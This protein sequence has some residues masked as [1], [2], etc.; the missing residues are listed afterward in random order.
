MSSQANV[1]PRRKTGRPRAEVQLRLLASKFDPA[2]ADAI[3]RV[4]QHRALQ[5]PDEQFT[6]SHAIRELVQAALSA[7]EYAK[8]IQ[9]P[10]PD[11]TSSPLE[12][13]TKKS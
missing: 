2:V 5:N 4:R 3:E 12:S 7:P 11:E 1:A 9:G 8:L 6:T 10:E 13:D